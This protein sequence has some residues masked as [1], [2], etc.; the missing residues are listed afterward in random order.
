MKAHFGTLLCL[1][2][3]TTV[4]LSAQITSPAV[5]AQFGADA[6]T[7]ANYFN[8]ID[9]DGP[10]D[11]FNKTAGAGIQVIDTAGAAAMLQQ[12][13]TDPSSR[14]QSFSRLMKQPPFSIVN[15]C[16]LLDAVFHRDYHGDD[17][18]VFASG[19][20]KNGMNPA[21]W[22]CPVSQS[23]PDKNEILDVFA[24]VR[25]A[26]PSMNDSLW[27]FGAISIENTTGNR[28]FDFELC[29]TEMYYDMTLRKFMN[30][31]PDAGHTSWTFDDSGRVIT[32][33]D[34][35]FSAEFSS[36]AMTGLEARIWIDRSS[37]L[38]NPVSF[39]WGG[40]FDGATNN[41][42]YGYASILPKTT[43]EFYTGLQSNNN[44]WAGPFGLIRKDNSLVT[45]YLP[46]QFM[47]FSVN[48]SKLGLD[49]A[50]YSVDI[51]NSPFRRVLVKTRASTSFS[52]ELK[53]FVAPIRMFKYAPVDAFAP[54]IYYC[55]TMPSV[56]VQVANPNPYSTY[57]WTTEDG[58]ILGSDSGTSISIHGPGTYYVH[59]TFHTQCNEASMDSVL[60]LYDTA[61]SLLPLGLTAFS[62]APA[63]NRA[64][65][66]W[67]ITGDQLVSSYVV[68]FS[69]DGR[70]FLT[71]GS[72]PSRKLQSGAGYSFSH[73]WNRGSG[74]LYY[75]LRI[76][77][78]SGHVTYS[79]IV[80]VTFIK[81]ETGFMLYPNPSSG[82]VWMS[83]TGKTKASGSIQIFDAQGRK[84]GSRL[85][86]LSPG[87][88][89]IKIN[90]MQSLQKGT[91]FIR[92]K[93]GEEQETRSIIIQ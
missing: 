37:L 8:G 9:Q 78:L 87:E 46:K 66:N 53:D 74:V 12:Y 22:T 45:D 71:A 67:Q 48:L 79:R 60:I 13:A 32:A 17:S 77:E 91:Y 52:S 69:E 44:T 25:R 73:P 19:S 18:T 80:A 82:D 68:E 27:M 28:Y 89:R 30:V 34:I 3:S 24:H 49:P 55:D 5:R 15:N 63:G 36:A 7:R 92:M 21:D 29:Q 16:V 64:E 35:I 2:M 41:A 33:G 86:M 81:N 39:S 93:T 62:A 61:C 43:G 76:N 56:T 83:A 20:N 26:G 31:G 1:I 10:D 58:L 72:V 6:D 75:R 50:A 88:N 38:K 42:T 40:E 11:W 59:Q 23:I 54:I 84:V 4:N 47:E 70:S 51:C 85:I 90:E 14:E 65:L 57:S